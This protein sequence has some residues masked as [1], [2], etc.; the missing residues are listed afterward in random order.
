VEVGGFVVLVW[1]DDGDMDPQVLGPFEYPADAQAW[2]D[3]KGK[4]YHRCKVDRM[5][6]G[7]I[8]DVKLPEH[9]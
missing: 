9:E 8:H 6:S 1:T 7:R 4:Y 2:V 3:K 5:L